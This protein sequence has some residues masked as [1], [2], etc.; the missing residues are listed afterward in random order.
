MCGL[1]SVGSVLGETKKLLEFH[2]AH[3][4]PGNELEFKFQPAVDRALWKKVHSLHPK[5]MALAYS[6]KA[7]QLS[8]V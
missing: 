2:S 3:E 4:R 8:L 5:T 6:F 7:R 1:K